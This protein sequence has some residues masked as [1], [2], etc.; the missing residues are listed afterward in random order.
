MPPPSDPKR[1][2]ES[3]KRAT[4][5]A[6]LALC[7][8]NGYTKVTV[9]GIAARAGVSKKTIYRWWPSKG[10]VVLDALHDAAMQ[11]TAFP[12]T[13]DLVADL[14]RQLT[15]LVG[16]FTSP[17]LRPATLGVFSEGLHDPDFANEVHERVISPRIEDFK[18]RLRKAVREGEL[19]PDTDED[20][21]MDLLYGPV[22][23]RLMVHL[24]LPD[25]A[26]LSKII[27]SALAAVRS[28][29]ERIASRK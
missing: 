22:Y 25:D 1:R 3:S 18:Q 16:V 14:H 27:D 19:P 2:S 4:L 9:E 12:D 29:P 10:A 13:G 15:G 20:L 5:E 28:T 6:A 8:E 21:V 26:Y 7:E 23:H 17:Q 11:A 24:P